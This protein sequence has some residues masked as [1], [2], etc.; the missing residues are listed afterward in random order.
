M[1]LGYAFLGNEYTY[2]LR[3]GVCWARNGWGAKHSSG[4]LSEGYPVRPVN[5][6]FLGAFPAPVQESKCPRPSW[7]SG[8]PSTMGASFGGSS[9]L[10]PSVTSHIVEGQ[11]IQTLHFS[12]NAWIW[13]NGVGYLLGSFN[14]SWIK[15][16]FSSSVMPSV[17]AKVIFVT[18]RPQTESW[19][20]S[21]RSLTQD[22][23]VDYT[24]ITFFTSLEMLVFLSS[25]GF[26]KR[27]H[28]S[29][30]QTFL[31]VDRTWT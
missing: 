19:S 25:S 22:W 11:K 17:W 27:A 8:G 21:L 2:V 16:L 28:F 29:L 1:V 5:L 24:A 18:D 3:V 30:K 23:L 31:T 14:T 9:L 4:S 7:D 10:F 13:L 12:S 15:T 20:V 26:W 6:S